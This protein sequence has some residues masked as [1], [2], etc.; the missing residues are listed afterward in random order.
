MWLF[1]ALHWGLTL[2]GK[3]SLERSFLLTSG[4]RA[5][6]GTKWEE[7]IEHSYGAKFSVCS[8]CC[9]LEIRC[10][11]HNRLSLPNPLE[12]GEKKACHIPGM[13]LAFI[14]TPGVPKALDGDLSTHRT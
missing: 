3:R 6:T 12:D 11:L 9:L 2:P 10:S 5:H 4:V 1:V 14:S 8:L 7:I 13:P